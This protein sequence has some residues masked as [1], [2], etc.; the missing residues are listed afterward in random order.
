MLDKDVNWSYPKGRY[1]IKPEPRPDVTT[2]DCVELGACG[3]MF[4][5]G[6]INLKLTWDGE[7]GK[8][9]SAEVL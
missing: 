3:A 8:L 1:R 9:K 2:F 4:E 7:T 5:D 6:Q